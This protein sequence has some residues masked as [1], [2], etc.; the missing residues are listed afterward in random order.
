[1][2]TEPPATE[3]VRIQ[4]STRDRDFDLPEKTG[5]ILVAT[6][7]SCLQSPTAPSPH[8]HRSSSEHD[9]HMLTLPLPRTDLRRYALSTLVNA[10]LAPTV[11]AA[12]AAPV[13]FD[14]LVDGALLRTSLAAHLAAR[15]LSPE[16]LLSVEYVRAR[17]PPARQAAFAHDDWVAAV[18]V[19]SASSLAAA[20]LQ[21]ESS[22]APASG[23]ER[24]LSASHDGILRV[25]GT[26]GQ[27]VAASTAPVTREA[28]DARAIPSLLAARFLSPSLLVSA[29]WDATVRVWSFAD[30]AVG[31]QR[32]QQ[33]H[34]AL[35]PALTLHGHT[36]P[37]GALA[38]HAPSGQV[39]SA[40]HDGTARL[41]ATS[42][43]AAS[44]HPAPAHLLPSAL[45]PPTGGASSSLHKRRRLAGSS[46][47]SLPSPPPAATS[48]AT[49]PHTPHRPV[50]AAL[51]APHDSTVAYTASTDRHLRTFDLATAGAA[52]SA[53]QLAPHAAL[54]CL[55]ALPA[56]RLL[57]AGTATRA[58]LLAD[59]RAAGRAAVA[60]TLRGHRN[61][62]TALAA[63]PEGGGTGAG[64]GY[65]LVS[66]S[67]DG[68]VRVWDVRNVRTDVASA[69]AG[70]G[71]ADGRVADALF[72]LGVGG[73]TRG[74]GGGADAEQ[75][76]VFG[77]AWDA[78]VGIVSA[79][80]RA[81]VV[82]Y[83]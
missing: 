50:T 35:T 67:L 63:E 38:V 21:L 83:R 66:G 11:V 26:S 4:L 25:W 31:Q 64:A 27:L 9:R 56:A 59:P 74:G 52:V 76:R 14:F 3:Q 78:H 20:H 39:L 48:L 70:A 75:G 29:G 10:L 15:G 2:T 40:S 51:F 19:L 72:A 69:R 54:T 80:E 43:A 17:L 23:H 1:M 46:S 77:V 41:W 81:G 61:A 82:V 12:G 32:Q 5:P 57:A 6:S 49:L 34:A 65:G 45:P 42:P 37:V 55:A 73:A 28:G 13:P 60:A 24:I 16:S 58:V 44:A 8:P 68:A 7:P 71:A 18:D 30:A 79:G 36:A 62:V 33:H 47:S 53:R 22:A